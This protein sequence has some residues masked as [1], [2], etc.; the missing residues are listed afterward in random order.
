M[1]WLSKQQAEILCK[2]KIIRIP[3]SGKEPLEVQGDKSGAV[4]GIISFL[5]IVRLRSAYVKVTQP[6]WL[7]FQTHQ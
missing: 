3:R 7:L 2:D 5:K 4:V 1:D 6:F